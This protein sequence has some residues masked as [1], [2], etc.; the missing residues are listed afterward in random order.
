MEAYEGGGF[1]YH[2][3]MPT[4][5][6]DAARRDEGNQAYGFDKVKEEQLE[7]GK[8]IRALLAEKGFRSVAAEGFEAPG[9]VVSYTDDDGFEPGRSLPTSGCRSRRVYR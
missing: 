5:T 1:A 9:V 6:H 4:D 2:A 7:L 8:R 3:T